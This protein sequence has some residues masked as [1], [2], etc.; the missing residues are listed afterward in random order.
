MEITV[1]SKAL[2]RFYPPL[3]FIDPTLPFRLLCCCSTERALAEEC[4][5]QW[6]IA[7]PGSRKHGCASELF[8]SLKSTSDAISP[9]R[10]LIISAASTPF[11]RNNLCRGCSL[12]LTKR[13]SKFP[14]AQQ[15]SIQ[16]ATSSCFVVFCISEKEGKIKTKFYNVMIC[17]RHFVSSYLFP[18]WQGSEITWRFSQ[19][20][21]NTNFLLI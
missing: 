8:G 13:S 21:W 10:V 9:Y 2:V 4:W 18:L 16:D 5:I 1:A 12:S 15:D 17:N 14:T 11:K 20:I 7:Y 19:S 3:L 6:H